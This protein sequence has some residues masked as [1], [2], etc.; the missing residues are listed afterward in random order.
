MALETRTSPWPTDCRQCHD[1]LYEFG[2]HQLSSTI[3]TTVVQVDYIRW[4]SNLDDASKYFSALPQTRYPLCCKSVLEK[5]Q[6]IP[7]LF[8]KAFPNWHPDGCSDTGLKHF[9]LSTISFCI[10][11][12][13]LICAVRL[14]EAR[15]IQRALFWAVSPSLPN[16]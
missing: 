12:L 10:L 11:S 4:F 15:E 8:S 5:L 2:K 13:T 3:Q 7:H 9:E 14:Q 6:D 1:W 16:L